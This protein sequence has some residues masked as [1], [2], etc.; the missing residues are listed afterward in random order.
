MLNKKSPIDEFMK[1][2]NL[3]IKHLLYVKWILGWNEH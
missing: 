1:K 2:H 3:L